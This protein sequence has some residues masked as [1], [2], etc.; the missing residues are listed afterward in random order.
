MSSVTRLGL[1][2]AGIQ[3]SATPALHMREA[4]EHGLTCIYELID[5]DVLDVG[6]SELPSLISNAEAQGFRGL[7]ITHPCK[8]DVI[9]IL[10]ELSPEARAVNAVNTVVFESAKRVGHNT[11]WWGFA[12]AFRRNLSDVPRNAVVQMGA[13]GGGSAV[14]YALLILGVR[15]LTIFDLV[16]DRAASL[17]TSLKPLFPDANISA[18]ADL[19]ASVGAADGLVNTTPVG[20]TKYP[21]VP[22]PLQC[23]RPD[24]WVTDIIYFPQDTALLQAAR[25]AGCKTMGGSDMAVYQA[26]EAF[27]LFNGIIADENR[28]RRH[29]AQLAKTVV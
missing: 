3:Q 1:I 19:V 18:G 25:A 16:V 2:G 24:L 26:V 22:V 14:A 4:A 11:D 8:Q 15:A 17:A 13:G 23:L 6:A 9:S 5:L 21:G 28:M 10:D 20:M 7:N 27:R 12:A 29:F